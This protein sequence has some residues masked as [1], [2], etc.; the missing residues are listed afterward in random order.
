MAEGAGHVGVGLLRGPTPTATP[1]TCFSGDAQRRRRHEQRPA[2]TSRATS[3]E[4]NFQH[5]F[6]GVR[7]DADLHAGRAGGGLGRLHRAGRVPERAPRR[8]RRARRGLP[9]DGVQDWT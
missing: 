6:N 4:M 7:G 9:A 5:A 1:A 2:S 3:R 8:V